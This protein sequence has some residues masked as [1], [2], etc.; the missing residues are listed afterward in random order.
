MFALIRVRKKCSKINERETPLTLERNSSIIIIGRRKAEQT[1]ALHV[2]FATREPVI[3]VEPNK[4]TSLRVL[5]TPIKDIN[6][7]AMVS[8]MIDD[9]VLAQLTS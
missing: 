9:V 6:V 8:K 2:W 4:T 5:A 1:I 3:G 7:R